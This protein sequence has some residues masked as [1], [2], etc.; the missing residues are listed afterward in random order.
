MSKKPLKLKNVPS[1]NAE[2]NSVDNS[3]INF[4]SQKRLFKMGD[5]KVGFERLNLPLRELSNKSG[6]QVYIDSLP[7]VAKFKNINYSI[8]SLSYNIGLVFVFIVYHALNTPILS[9]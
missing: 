6:N 3:S 9:L 2:I 8:R 4:I 1:E 5:F 7:R